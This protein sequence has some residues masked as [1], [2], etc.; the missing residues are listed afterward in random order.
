M[1]V[2][3]IQC[4][5]ERDVT[6]SRVKTFKFCGYKC[7]GEWRRVHYR[8][9]ANPRWTGGKRSKKCQGCGVTIEWDGQP[10]STF[11]KRKFCTKTCADEHGFRHSGEQHPRWTGG[12]RKRPSEQ[13][14][15]AERVISRDKATCRT[16]GAT[17]VELHAHHVKSYRD[18]PELRWQVSNGITLCARC[19]WA[20]HS[21]SN[22][23]A[24]NSGNPQHEKGGGNPEPSPSRK[25][26]EGVT[27][28]GRAYRRVEANCAECGTF[29]SRRASD[30]TGRDNLF[31]SKICSSRFNQRAGKI[32]RKRPRQ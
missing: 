3:C 21:A 25:V 31:C 11:R 27:I 8:G 12:K 14:A 24:V 5:A 32:G 1:Q 9:E 19:H 4:G 29:T 18:H 7:R 16:C 23:N 26:R 20:V 2:K 28:R 10:I 15:W 17:G 30:A 6:P 13:S 22:A